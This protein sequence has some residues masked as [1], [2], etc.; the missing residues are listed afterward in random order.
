LK[1]LFEIYIPICDTTFVFD[2]SLK[3]PIMIFKSEENTETIYNQ[4]IYNELKT[5]QF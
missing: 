4:K 3:S 1:N 2:N 5:Q